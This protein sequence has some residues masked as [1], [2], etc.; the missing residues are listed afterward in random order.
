MR[1]HISRAPNTPTPYSSYTDV[2]PDETQDAYTPDRIS[3]D[4]MTGA[5]GSKQERHCSSSSAFVPAIRRVNHP[6]LASF[7]LSSLVACS[8]I[9]TASAL[10]VPFDNCL[11]SNYIYSNQPEGEAQLQWVPL[12]V[13][14]VFD[15]EDPAHNLMVTV[16]GNVTG[17]AGSDAL[18]A[19]NS[20]DWDD[21]NK[22]LNG[23]IQNEPDQSVPAAQ[24]K[25]TTLHT[26]VDVLTYEPFV[27]NVNFCD[28]L[29]NGS[30]PLGPVFSNI[31]TYVS[32][33]E[34]GKEGSSFICYI[35]IFMI[36]VETRLLGFLRLIF[37]M[38]L[39]RHTRLRR[40]PLPLSSGMETKPRPRSDAYR[41]SLR[42]TSEGSHGLSNLCLYLF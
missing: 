39:I 27:S 22:V 10:M 37:R 42:Q 24:R 28:N 33:L 2:E 16:W 26:K 40:L 12:H 23:K 1:S 11:D 7:V 18:P 21:P 8:W 19:W 4:K 13:E 31:S 14:A 41:Q 25:V 6:S 36:Y 17:R 34:N 20:T 9:R 30:C 3:S 29:I 15:T 32:P 38:I 35:L 5:C